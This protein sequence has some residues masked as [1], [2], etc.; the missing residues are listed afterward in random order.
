MNDTYEIRINTP[1]VIIRATSNGTKYA[2]AIS[3]DLKAIEKKH[4]KKF[5]KNLFILD[6]IEL[7]FQSFSTASC[8]NIHNK[9]CDD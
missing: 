2:M 4:P 9:Y 1:E 6:E 8:S 5:S 7:N 3:T